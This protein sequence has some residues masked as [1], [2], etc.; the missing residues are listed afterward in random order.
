MIGCWPDFEGARAVSLVE[1]GRLQFGQVEG[2][3]GRAGDLDLHDG[4][5]VRPVARQD[6]GWAIWPT[7]PDNR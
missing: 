7:D 2:R 6:H 3:C 1:E 4:A 5:G